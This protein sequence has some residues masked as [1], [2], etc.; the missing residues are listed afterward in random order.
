[1]PALPDRATMRP[2]RPRSQRTDRD[3]PCAL[4]RAAL[5]R[6][7][8]RMSSSVVQ[9]GSRRGDPASVAAPID[10]PVLLA[11]PAGFA[12]SLGLLLAAA[13]RLLFLALLPRRPR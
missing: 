8:A 9:L 12:V 11:S 3:F 1:M 6:S 10:R 5:P 4:L 7:A 13:R 2:R